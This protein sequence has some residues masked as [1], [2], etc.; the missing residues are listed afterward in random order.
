MDRAAAAAVNNA[1]NRAEA[2]ARAAALQTQLA[3]P[4]LLTANQRTLFQ[5][6][7]AAL[8]VPPPVAETYALNQQAVTL[9]VLRGTTLEVLAE[10]TLAPGDPAWRL[11]L[12]HDGWYVLAKSVA[13]EAAGL[14]LLQ[15]TG[16]YPIIVR[17]ISV[18]LQGGGSRTAAEYLRINDD[19][20]IVDAIPEIDGV[21]LPF[22]N[23]I[24][25]QY[26]GHRPL[27]DYL[28]LHVAPFLQWSGRLLLPLLLAGVLGYA[29]A[30]YLLPPRRTYWAARLWFALPLVAWLL[31][32]GIG[33]PLPISD[34]RRWGGLLLTLVLS[35]VG[36]I[37]SFP[38]GVL[39]AL[40]RRSHLPVISL[41][42][43][44]F[45]ELVRGVPLITVL[46]MAQLLVPLINPNLAEVDNVFRAMVG[47]TIFSAAYLA[48]NVR[49][50]LQSIPH[51]Q[52]EAARALGL[53]NFQVTYFITLPQ[54]LR[55][56]IPALV[57]QFI[58]LFKDTSLVAIVGLIDLT[59]VS[60]AVLAQTEFSGL[61]TET[62]VFIAVIYLV[63]CYA[64]A[65]VSRRIEASGSGAA[66]RV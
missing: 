34:T 37:A 14:S 20:E 5:E 65:Y 38:L 27:R 53:N 12:P 44:L 39:L 11:T 63:F 32:Y 66:R 6:Q 59:G 40:G 50:G 55:A 62:A 19:L 33:G 58:S 51:G 1:R 60:R 43:T 42:C 15:T 35:A 18:A 54:A 29:L 26:R 3:N 7:L 8:Q 48:E 36:I 28:R 21:A 45:I 4:E 30:R 25:N 47:I 16:I 56:V 22:A 23:I 31:I 61:Q 49:G 17:D 13:A 10:T 24:D 41:V 9:Q 52:E 57:G 46:F 2:A 64:M